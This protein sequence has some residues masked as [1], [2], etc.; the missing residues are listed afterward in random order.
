MLLDYIME[1]LLTDPVYGGNPN[2][3]GWQW[4]K[5]QPGFPRP[6]TPLKRRY[7]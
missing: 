6:T 4:L 2:S 3:I 5:H 7:L 1:A